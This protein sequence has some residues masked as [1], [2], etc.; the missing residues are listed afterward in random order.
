MVLGEIQKAQIS[1]FHTLFWKQCGSSSADLIWNLVHTKL[2]YRKMALF[3]HYC[4]VYGQPW[5]LN[6]ERPF[7]LYIKAL[8]FHFLFSSF[9]VEGTLWGNLYLV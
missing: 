9:K 8:F 6:W 3:L 4:N 5:Y 7:K 2:D 1:S